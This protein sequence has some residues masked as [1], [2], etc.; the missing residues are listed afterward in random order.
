MP[1]NQAPWLYLKEKLWQDTG[2]T[3]VWPMVLWIVCGSTNHKAPSNLAMLQLLLQ[4]RCYSSNHESIPWV[5]QIL[6]SGPPSQ[7]HLLAFTLLSMTISS[8]N[9]IGICEKY[10]MIFCTLQSSSTFSHSILVSSIW[11]LFQFPF[12]IDR[13]WNYFCLNSSRRFYPF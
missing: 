11:T 7:I 3:G 4:P 9:K 8:Q 1:W 2:V 10:C 12:W 13:I 5:F 6:G